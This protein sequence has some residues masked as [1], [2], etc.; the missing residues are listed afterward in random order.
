MTPEIWWALSGAAC[1]A[2]IQ[3]LAGTLI[4]FY[5]VPFLGGFDEEDDLWDHQ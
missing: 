1:L 3:M 5:G 4:L 2:S